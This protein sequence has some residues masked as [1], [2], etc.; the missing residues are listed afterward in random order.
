[1]ARKRNFKIAKDELDEIILLL[2]WARS[3]FTTSEYGKI[4]EWIA[5][6]A[7]IRSELLV[8]QEED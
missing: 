7:S 3:M 4:T 1:M 8:D 6:Y 2:E 5:R